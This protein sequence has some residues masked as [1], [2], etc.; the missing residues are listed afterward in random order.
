M[1]TD[2][3][4]PAAPFAWQTCLDLGDQ[5]AD[6]YQDFV[7]APLL[8]M[9]QPT[10]A[11]VLEL[12]CATG[13]FGQALKQRFPAASV[14]GIEQ[15]RAAAALAATRLDRVICG[16]L[17]DLD[18]AAE[19][20]RPGEFDAL[21]A[22]DVLEH[23]VNPWDVLVRV[24]PLLAPNAQVLASIPNVRNAMLLDALV[25]Q[26]RWEYGPRGLLDITHL[27]FFTLFEIRRM[28]EETGY[29]VEGY[30]ATISPGLTELYR[31]NKDSGPVNIEVG[32]FRI[33][34]LS[35]AEFN[36]LCTEQFLVRARPV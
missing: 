8:D 27:R 12:G 7:N 29:R 21:V 24:K 4:P 6:R 18:L 15:G 31:A 33:A 36:E 14:V 26:G 2:P 30:G 10:P 16:R 3:V 35:H 11:R 13:M 9:V 5:A 19:G 22:A 25:S 17:E 28:F 1:P 34:N 32:R 23:V 20:L